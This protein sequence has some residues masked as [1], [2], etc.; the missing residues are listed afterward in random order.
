MKPAGYF[1]LVACCIALLSGCAVERT[2]GGINIRPDLDEIS[3]TR[4]GEFDTPSG[5]A[6]LRKNRDSG[7]S[8]KVSNTMRVIEIGDFDSVDLVNSFT[9]GDERVAILKV[10]GKFCQRSYAMYV[11]S[12]TK[13]YGVAR[14]GDCRAA[15]EFKSDGKVLTAREADSASPRFWEYRDQ[16]LTGPMSVKQAAAAAT[17]RRKARASWLPPDTPVSTAK[18]AAAVDTSTGPGKVDVPQPSRTIS[19][20]SLE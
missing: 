17:G 8:I 14:F 15:M 18:R 7:Y 12:P 13:D 20:V 10:S 3:G 16:Q 2:N 5:K 1:W 11:F 19:R 9:V 4:L 6:A